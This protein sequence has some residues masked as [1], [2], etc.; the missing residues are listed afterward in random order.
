MIFSF[1]FWSFFNNFTLTYYAP[2]KKVSVSAA[3]FATLYT[4]QALD[5][6]GTGLTAYTAKL[7]GETVDLTEVTTIPAN[8]GVVLKGDEGAYMIP[9]IESSSTDPEDLTG[10]VSASTDYNAFVGEG[11]YIYGLALNG[12]QAQFTKVTS[13]SVAPGKAFL[14]VSTAVSSKSLRA[15]VPGQPTEVTAPEVVETEEPEVLFNMAGIPVGKDFKGYVINQKGEKR[16]Q[17]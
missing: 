14:K 5:F 2:A 11:Y 7:K 13:G 1:C 9:V 12:G 10:N 16:L 15:V 17:R 4:D 6:T 8:T 3:G